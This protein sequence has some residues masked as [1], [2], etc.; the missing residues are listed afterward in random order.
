MLATH[1]DSGIDSFDVLVSL[2]EESPGKLT[3]GTTGASSLQN[4]LTEKMQEELGI[5]H[6][7]TH[8]PFDGGSQAIAALAGQQTDACVAMVPDM[9]GNI[10][11]GVFTPLCVYTSERIS[12]LPDVPCIA[13]LGYPDIAMP[14]WYGFAAPAGTPVEILDFWDE[15][16]RDT[17]TDPEVI[18]IFQNLNQTA[19]Y[20]DRSSF[21]QLWLDTYQKNKD[22]LDN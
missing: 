21:T 4:L 15:S 7:L 14:T 8:V 1:A 16:I 10:D 17:L 2:A 3:Y 19:S 5:P 11:A 9:L 22:M 18:E 6:S 20:L 13:E 12:E